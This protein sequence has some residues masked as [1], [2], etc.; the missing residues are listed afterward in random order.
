MINILRCANEN[1]KQYINGL[2]KRT[3]AET[4]YFDMLEKAM[5]QTL[6]PPCL[7]HYS[8]QRKSFLKSM[9][10]KSGIWTGLMSLYQHGYR[11]LQ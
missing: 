2:Q 5:I 6:M 8:G 4:G 10:K 7:E 11:K 3:N 9:W 1:K